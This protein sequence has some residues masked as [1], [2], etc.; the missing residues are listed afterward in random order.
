MPAPF[1]AYSLFIVGKFGW[2]DYLV[3]IVVASVGGY[4]PDTSAQ[5]HLE[6]IHGTVPAVASFF[7]HTQE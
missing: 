2:D 1:S 5:I 6:E 4:V 7:C 3:F